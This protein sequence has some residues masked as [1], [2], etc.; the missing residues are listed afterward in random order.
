MD[1]QDLLIWEGIPGVNQK[2][3]VA[4]DYV[5]GITLGKERQ[6]SVPTKT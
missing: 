2:Y 5:A 1:K 6:K 4:D 3:K